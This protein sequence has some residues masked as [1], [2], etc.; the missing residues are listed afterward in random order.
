[1]SKGET[2]M[3]ALLNFIK[4]LADI[5]RVRII[6][7][8]S[9]GEL[10]LCSLQEIL[11]LSPSTVS[12]HVS[13]LKQAGL[14]VSRREGKWRYF[15]LAPGLEKTPGGDL[16]KWLVRNLE[17]DHKAGIQAEKVA[18]LREQQNERCAPCSDGLKKRQKRNGRG[19]VG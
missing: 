6:Y 12:R 16:V 13:V 4:A 14:V 8:L 18:L 5:Q 1:M 9:E 19:Q 10:C 15:R 11:E 17:D 7:A 2:A 3:D